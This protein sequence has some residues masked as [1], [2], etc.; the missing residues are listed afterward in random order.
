MLQVTSRRL[1]EFKAKERRNGG[2]L[3]V[4][5]LTEIRTPVLSLKGLR[6]SPLDDEGNGRNSITL[7][8]LGQVFMNV[9]LS[10]L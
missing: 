1:E 2:A 6:P 3:F 8:T 9:N 4:C 10:K 7:P 5:A